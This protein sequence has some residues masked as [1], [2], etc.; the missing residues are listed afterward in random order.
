MLEF[1]QAQAELSYLLLYY[2]FQSNLS[3]TRISHEHFANSKVMEMNGIF[4]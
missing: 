1:M 4:H 3:L 2:N